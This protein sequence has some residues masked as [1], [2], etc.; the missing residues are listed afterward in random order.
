[1]NTQF[2]N[3][4]TPNEVVVTTTYTIDLGPD[5]AGA[6]HL[7]MPYAMLE[8]IRDALFSSV[9]GEQIE[10]DRRWLRLLS[11]QVQA[12]EVQLITNLCE[13]PLTLEQVMSLKA[14]D[15][16]SA[17]VPEVVI[18]EVD[19]V[20]VMECRYGVSNGQY[21]LQVLRMVKHDAAEES[22]SGSPAGIA[23]AS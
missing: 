8:P 11:R 23:K 14:G 15:V 19:G 4:A 22:T 1:M 12:A 18:A 3:V 20:P 6:I 7:C 13:V 9:Q 10:L 2:T 17:H 16:I 5:M 21:A